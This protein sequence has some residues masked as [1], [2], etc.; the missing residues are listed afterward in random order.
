M[1][2][3]YP[4]KLIAWVS[5]SEITN[6]MRFD[7]YNQLHTYIH[8]THCHKHIHNPT[9]HICIY[10]HTLIFILEAR[11]IFILFHFRW[12]FIQN[13]WML[14]KF[15]TSSRVTHHSSV[16][17]HSYISY[18]KAMSGIRPHNMASL[19]FWLQEWIY[20]SSA[21][22][23]I[24]SLSSSNQSFPQDFFFYCFPV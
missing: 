13:D 15:D 24:L 22:Y 14:G 17:H 10:S 19:L 7:L 16:L 4:D 6:K 1:L 5:W 2:F 8:F 3:G 12:V 18:I 9:I 21:W 23:A 11:C 20:K